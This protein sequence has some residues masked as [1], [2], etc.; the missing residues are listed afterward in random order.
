MKSER[1]IVAEFAKEIREK[2][3]IYFEVI[4]DSGCMS[5]KKPFDAFACYRG[6]FFV[7]EFKVSLLTMWS[8]IAFPASAWFCL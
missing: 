6:H 2:S 3:D 4:K 7:F 8:G 5:H 1:K